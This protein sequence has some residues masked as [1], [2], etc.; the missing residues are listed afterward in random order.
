MGVLLLKSGL[1]LSGSAFFRFL[2]R[3]G[4]AGILSPAYLTGSRFDWEG[5]LLYGSGFKGR[6]KQ[7]NCWSSKRDIKKKF[8]ANVFKE[9]IGKIS[10]SARCP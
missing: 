8:G 9:N 6:R 5:G 4:E 3:T 1:Y 10:K 2:R 7:G